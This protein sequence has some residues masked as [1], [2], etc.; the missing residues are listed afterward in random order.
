MYMN[1]IEPERTCSLLYPFHLSLITPLLP[2]LLLTCG[3][4]HEAIS[5]DQQ[6]SSKAGSSLVLLEKKEPKPDEWGDRKTLAD[7]MGLESIPPKKGRRN[8]TQ[9]RQGH[10]GGPELWSLLCMH[11][12]PTCGQLGAQKRQ[13]NNGWRGL[14]GASHW[15]VQEKLTNNAK[16][17]ERERKTERETEREGRNKNDWWWLLEN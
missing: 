5:V 12:W 11:A 9:E 17:T 2:I 10:L 15:L 14:K 6:K 13:A 8:T 7:T 16:A 4:V 1:D 3:S